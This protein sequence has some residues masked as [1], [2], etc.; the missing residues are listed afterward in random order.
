MQKPKHHLMIDEEVIDRMCVH[1]KI[2]KSD[3]V[4]EI[5]AGTGN[6][7]EKLLEKGAT[8]YAIESDPAMYSQLDAR[9]S[10][11]EHLHTFH[12]SALKIKFPRFN[13]VVSNLPYSIS[14]KITERILMHEFKL[15]ILVYQ[16]EF[17]E[18][19][20]AKPE[21]KNYRFIS[22]LAQCCADIEILDHIPPTAF[23]PA[24][25]VWSCIVSIKPKAAAIKEF[26][27]FLHSLF[28]H[29]NKKIGN[30]LADV[31]REFR[32]KR[33]H[34]LK[35]AELLRLYKQISVSD[36]KNARGIVKG[37]TTQGLRDESDRF[38]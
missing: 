14:R 1:A 17:A 21:Q 30:L 28:N 27:D 20:L 35:P 7:T 16:K 33:P 19:L 11:N 22:V 8:V 32:D 12:S 31:P 10:D 38:D 9:F 2:R 29:K 6:L 5:G 34:E 15:G 18:K 37:I 36:I 26:I 3:R 25:N 13:K 24:P 23:D 4:L